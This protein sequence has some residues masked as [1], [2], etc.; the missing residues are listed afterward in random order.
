M[1]VP[2]I[3]LYSDDLYEDIFSSIATRSEPRKEKF[4]G[5]DGILERD[6]SIVCLF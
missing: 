3:T 5:H 1:I 6:V 2:S 4:K